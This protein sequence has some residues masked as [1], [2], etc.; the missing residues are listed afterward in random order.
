M[1]E[2]LQIRNMTASARGTVAEPGR[3]VRQKA[4]LNRAILARGW[5]GSVVMLSYKLPPLGGSLVK[6]RA[7][8][9]SQTCRV[10][11][12]SA[13]ENR[14]SQAVFRC[15]ACG[16][17]ANADTNASQVLLGRYERRG[18]TPSQDV[19]GKGRSLPAKRQLDDL[20][21]SA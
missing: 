17:A 20:R 19:E 2:D 15:V 18:S 16:H 5:S 14:E 4:G 8:Y 1:V 21:L 13:P 12:H 7:A 11:E 9:S 10:C 6:E 3:N